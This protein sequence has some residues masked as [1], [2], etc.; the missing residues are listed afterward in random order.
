MGSR[1]TAQTQSVRGAKGKKGAAWRVSPLA[2]FSPRVPREWLKRPA[3]QHSRSLTFSENSLRGHTGHA[4]TRGRQ[5][6][7]LCEMYLAL[8]ARLLH[9]RF[10]AP[11]ERVV[12]AWG[13][14][15]L[16]SLD[17]KWP[18]QEVLR[19]WRVR[20]AQ[21]ADYTIQWREGHV[22]LLLR[23][24]ANRSAGPSLHSV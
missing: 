17:S 23:A 10:A 22:Y 19:N 7:N 5:G 13:R 21:A 3:T 1:R 6:C 16:F 24:R 18:R 9:R 2:T 8:S 4:S 11:S 12:H 14:E 20:S 15:R